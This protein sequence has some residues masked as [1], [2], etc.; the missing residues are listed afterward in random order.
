M[1]D[2]SSKIFSSEKQKTIAKLGA[3]IFASLFVLGMSGGEAAYFYFAGALSVLLSNYM[4][5]I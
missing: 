5:E 1:P 4:I 2:Q 3:V